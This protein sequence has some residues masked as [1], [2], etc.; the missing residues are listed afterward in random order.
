MPGQPL[1]ERLQQRQTSRRPVHHRHR[2]GP[3]ERHHRIAGH[4]FQQP[5]ESD[6]LWPVGVLVPVGR[7]VH[8]R[9]RRLQLIFAHRALRDR[10]GD[11]RP[12][13][14]DQ[15]LIPARPVLLGQRYQVTIGPGAGR[16]AR[17]GEQHQ[18]EQPGD[19]AVIRP[20]VPHRP[21]QPDRL[22]GQLHPVQVGADAA[23]V[24]LVED[25]IQHMQHRPQP[26][27]PVLARRQLERGALDALFGPADP[28]RHRCLRHQKGVG[29]LGG[30]QA[31]D[32]AQGQ[33]D[34]RG[35][36][37]TRMAAQEQQQQGVVPIGD[38][39]RLRLPGHDLFPAP[40]RLLAAK[41]VGHFPYGRLDQPAA[42][43]VR[44]A[45]FRPTRRRR[46]QR[47]LYGVLRRGEVAITP[48]QHTEDRRRRL[49]QQVLD[50]ALEIHRSAPGSEP[51]TCRT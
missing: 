8:R 34:R 20:D 42:R 29:N 19:L 3:V 12:A 51:I 23:G 30:R 50:A 35:R 40:P 41:L 13:F 32:R 16:P 31:A 25:Q 6:D 26:R 4:P 24:A 21:G 15:S 28:L 14:D 2:N 9:D 43:I 7:V 39:G 44:H 17:I 18:R 10:I 22:A 11:Q 45:V 49:T 36:R 37:Q 46:Q 5:V 48:D 38:S 1:I 47:L 27:R 33:R